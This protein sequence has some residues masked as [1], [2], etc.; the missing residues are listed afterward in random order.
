[1]YEDTS[2]EHQ[3][4]HP[5]KARFIVGLI[6]IILSFVGLVFSSFSQNA[7]WVYW[8]I[9]GGLFA[10]LSIWLSWYL[11]KKTAS[12]GIGTL[13]REIF[14]WVALILG[15]LLFSLFV[16]VGM[17]GKF[18]AGI[19]ILTILSMTLFIAGV[20]IDPSFILIGT[21]LG[22]FAAGSAYLASYLY[23]VMLPVA[24][25]SVILLFLFVYFKK[26]RKRTH[27]S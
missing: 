26:N 17:M 10:I 9:A 8:R 15:I 14:H 21:A 3:A 27:L 25:L 4:A 18:E 1:M 2:P 13:F 22:L 23:K 24:I 5:W 11:R 19:A 20:Y 16:E 6:M 12:F 7:A